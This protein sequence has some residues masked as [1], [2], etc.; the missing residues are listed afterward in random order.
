M[1]TLDEVIKALENCTSSVIDGCIYGCP[2]SHLVEE[3][4]SCDEKAIPEMQKD[5]LHYLKEYQNALNTRIYIPDGYTSEKT[6]FTHQ[7]FANTFG[8]EP[9][10]VRDFMV[11]TSQ[12]LGNTS[13]NLVCPKCHS[14]FVILPE[15]NNP[16]TWDELKQMEGKP[17]WVEYE[18]YTPDWEVIENIGAMRGS[19]GDITGNFVETHMSVLHK[20][21]MG[22]TWQ[23]YR[24]E[25]KE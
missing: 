11:G 5:A 8:K 23:A 14:E 4:E 15:A 21:D 25:R 16:L 12:N 20:D 6:G 7:D 1:K 22:K 18:G 24:K 9:H 17:V 3:G 19:I 13:Q 10:F 2:Y